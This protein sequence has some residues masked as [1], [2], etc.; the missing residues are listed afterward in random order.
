MKESDLDASIRM[1]DAVRDSPTPATPTK[2]VPAAGAD[3][4]ATR[5]SKVEYD[6]VSKIVSDLYS[7][8][9]RHRKW[10]SAA[11][12]HVLGGEEVY[13]EADGGDTDKLARLVIALRQ[14]ILSAGLEIDVFNF[15]DPELVVH[16]DVNKLVYGTLTYMVKPDSVADGFLQGTDSGVRPGRDARSNRLDQGLRAP[17]S[18]AEGRA[19]FITVPDQGGPTSHLGQGAAAR[20]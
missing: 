12:A 3:T 11:R 6:N 7:T 19:F 8:G 13:F 18:S 4:A 2:P 1:Q 20:S 17:S 14:E 9:R 15:D 5:A 10:A 16:E